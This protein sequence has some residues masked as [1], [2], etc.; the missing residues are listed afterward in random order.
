M[1]RIAHCIG[2]TARDFEGTTAEVKETVRQI[3][4]KY[5]LYR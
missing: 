4:E 2:M 3:C 1:R 5:P